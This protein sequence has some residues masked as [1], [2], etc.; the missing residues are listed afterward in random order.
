MALY[1]DRKGGC[2]RLKLESCSRVV[3]ELR[4]K[5]SVVD[6]D[7]SG[8]RCSLSVVDASGQ[9]FAIELEKLV[10]T[11]VNIL[12]LPHKGGRYFRIL[13]DDGPRNVGDVGQ[14]RTNIRTFPGDNKSEIMQRKLSGDEE[15][16]PRPIS[17]SARWV[18]RR[19][20]SSMKPWV[21]KRNV[22]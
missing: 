10:A 21:Q 3:E 17:S 14:H 19:L 11:G 6:V 5:A 8:V 9:A 20:R 12:P 1:P 18:L 16:R 13:Y 22:R 15:G 7:A 2:R 4:E